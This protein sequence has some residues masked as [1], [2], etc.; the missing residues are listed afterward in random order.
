[1]D[2]NA[3]LNPDD[4]SHVSTETSDKEIYHAVMDSIKA[5]ESIDIN[6]GDNVDDDSPVEPPPTRREVLKALST[7]GKCLEDLNH[8][9]ACEL[10]TLLGTFNRQL[11]LKEIQ[12]MR[13]TLVTGFFQKSQASLFIITYA[14]I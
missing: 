2:I 12:N 5:R 11:R 10:D 13:P 9:I 3:L 6:G 7:I 4:E 1:M 14:N 8:P